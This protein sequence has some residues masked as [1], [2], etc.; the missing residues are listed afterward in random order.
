MT[1]GD[2]DAALLR[3]IARENRHR[4]FAD[5][6]CMLALSALL[7][8]SGCCHPT[9]IPHAVIVRPPPCLTTPAPRPPTTEDDAAWPA[10]WIRLSA[11]AALVERSCLVEPRPIAHADP[12]PA[13]WTRQASVTHGE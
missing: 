10:H 2:M 4:L 5:I 1:R 9:T 11:W 7:W 6:A 3:E 8:S 12:G 13:W